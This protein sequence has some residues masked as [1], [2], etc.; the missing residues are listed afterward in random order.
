MKSW[1]DRHK[2]RPALTCG[3]FMHYTPPSH[4]ESRIQ[5]SCVRW[6]RLQYPGYIL[7]A[8]PNGGRRGKT[9]ASIM[10]GEGVLAGTA[11][12]FPALPSGQHHGLFIE[13]K[14]KAGRQSPAQKDF[15]KRAV[16][17]G[18]GYVICQSLEEFIETVNNYLKQQ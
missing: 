7:F 10:K 6:F 9:E 14:T 13:M 11:D 12:L 2:D 5:Q 16:M 1:L 18:Y 3:K 17:S 8:A 15:G 4:E